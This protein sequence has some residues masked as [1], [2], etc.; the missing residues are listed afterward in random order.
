MIDTE[1]PDLIGLFWS[2]LAHTLKF[3]EVATTAPTAAPTA[4]PA[5]AAPT[6]VTDGEQKEYV[7]PNGLIYLP[8]NLM[9]GEVKTQD[10][11]LVRNAIAADLTV[12]LYGEPGCGKTALVEAAFGDDGLVTVQGTVE[13]ETADFVGS[14]VQQ[15]DGTYQWVDGPLLVAMEGDGTTGRKLLVDEIALIDSRVMAVVYGV[16]DGRGELVVTQNPLRGAV[17]AKP[18]F[19]VI[20][21]CNPNVPGAQMSDALLSR[22]AIHMEMTTDWSLAS[23]LG[24]AAKIVQVTRNLNEKY[25]RGELTQA[26]QLRELIQFRDVARQFGEQFA[27]RNFL[28]QI[29]PENRSIA[30]GAIEAVF[31]QTAGALVV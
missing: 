24:I 29:R 6:I 26:P 22:F 23:K 10:V 13:T 15:P 3:A 31:G 2:P 21:A 16:M 14:W 5:P 12:L 28:S 8:R 27:L 30:A 18:G 20:G 25:A 7:R 11:T 4:T 17:R 1:T 9:V 19:A